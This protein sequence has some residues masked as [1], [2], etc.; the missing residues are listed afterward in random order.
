MKL[1][2]E[3]YFD[4]FKNYKDIINKSASLIA[5]HD[6]MIKATDGG[7]NFEN[8]HNSKSLKKTIDLYFEKLTEYKNKETASS[9]PSNEAT[10]PKPAKK[11]PAP[12]APP[13]EAK[14][15]SKP[16]A[17]KP[18]VPKVK[19]EKEHHGTPVEHIPSDIA[20]VKRYIGLHDKVKTYDQV[21]AIWRAF[22]KAIVEHKVTKDSPYKSEVTVMN[23]S[24]KAALG[25]AMAEGSLK[26]VIPAAKLK[27]YTAIANSV[28]K[29]VAVSILLEFIN[30]SGKT[31]MKERATK[32]SKRI[33]K[34]QENGTLANDRYK[35]EVKKAQTALDAYLNKETEVL[36]LN[37]FALS[38]IG[39]I[40]VFGCACDKSLKGI[41]GNQN[42]VVAKLMEEKIKSLTPEEIN[43]ALKDTIVPSLCKLI[44]EKLIEKKQLT[45]HAIRNSHLFSNSVGFNSG[46]STNANKK[47]DFGT[48]LM[49]MRIRNAAAKANTPTHKSSRHM[50]LSG[51]EGTSFITTES[52]PAN[53]LKIMSANELV[54][55][56]FRTMGLTGKYKRLIGDP[57]PG[58]SAMIYGKPKQGKSTVA[59]D[60]A[61]EFTRH[62]KVLY[63]AFEEGHGYTLQDKV[64]RN[65]ANVPGLDFAN[66]LP[67]DLHAYQFVFIDSVSDA[68]LDESAF[69]SLIKSNKP[70]TSILGVFHATKDGKFRGGQ[71]YAHDV[72]VLIKVEEGIAYAQ[73]RFAAPEQINI[74]ALTNSTQRLAA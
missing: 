17:P 14:P 70:Q 9:K 42:A 54:N 67:Q 25:P 1:T 64:I 37:D 71:T 47:Y 11:T 72:D 31:G 51:T 19:A 27:M 32:L 29:S 15:K 5:L 48:E 74:H 30:I 28:E 50:G 73:G 36:H 8:Y 43:R 2:I 52:E 20:L 46:A 23:N 3:N 45:M 41:I 57:E 62:G 6:F 16:A 12:N 53:D 44:A 39:E 68:G 59:I 18:Q 13:K 4:Q 35:Q 55:Q 7:K 40:A 33:A 61:K 66:K 63:C 56:K 10:A 38:G 58:F 26:L 22:N 21:L 60:M 69:K 49:D 34:A 65:N 24:L